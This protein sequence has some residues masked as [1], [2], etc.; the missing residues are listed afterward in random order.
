M[1]KYRMNN[2]SMNVRVKKGN[3]EYLFLN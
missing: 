1:Y 2:M 3:M